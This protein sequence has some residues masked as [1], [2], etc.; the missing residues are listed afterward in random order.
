MSS[1]TTNLTIAK[2]TVGSILVDP[3]MRNTMSRSWLHR[4]GIPYNMGIYNT[5]TKCS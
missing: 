3:S 5:R 2:C 1:L 4:C